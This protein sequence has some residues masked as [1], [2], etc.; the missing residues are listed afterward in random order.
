MTV[1]ELQV[2]ITAQTSGLEK[3]LN[4][5][6]AQLGGLEKTASRTSGKLSSAFKSMFKG[7]SVVAIVAGLTKLGKQAVSTASE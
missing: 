6:K 3:Q 4:S 5:V 7:F 2:L 1:E